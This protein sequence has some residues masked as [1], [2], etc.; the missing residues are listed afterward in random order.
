MISKPYKNNNTIVTIMDYCN[1]GPLWNQIIDIVD[2][3]SRFDEFEA[4]RIFN[5]IGK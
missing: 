2:T 5:K 3:Q 1:G 4:A